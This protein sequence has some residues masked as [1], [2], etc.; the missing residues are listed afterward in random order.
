[1]YYLMRVDRKSVTF[2][3]IGRGGGVVTEFSTADKPIARQGDSLILA[4]GSNLKLRFLA[5]ASVVSVEGRGIEQE[6]A[7]DMEQVEPPEEGGGYRH[8]FKVTVERLREPRLGQLMYSLERVSNFT[9]PGLNFRHHSRVSEADVET[10]RTGEVHAARSIYF[11]LLQYLPP[12]WRSH[13]DLAAR[14]ARA[15]K[16]LERNQPGEDGDRLPLEELMHAIYEA[17]IRPAEMAAQAM[18]RIHKLGPDFRGP[19]AELGADGS[20]DTWLNDFLHMAP[21]NVTEIR[22]AQQGFRGASI[23]VPPDEEKQWRPYRW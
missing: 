20:P 18:E 1:M 13:L 22:E 9:R 7:G 2:E 14:Q 10:I 8:L 21:R 17:A 23:D 4:S 12:E 11:G 3:E 5:I 16:T 6:D 15:M 19:Y